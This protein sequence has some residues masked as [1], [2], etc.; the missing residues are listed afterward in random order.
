MA[1]ITLKGNP[2]NTCGDLP[3]VGSAAPEFSL[4]GGGLDDVTL[5]DFQG[6]NVVMSIVPSFDTP[7]CATSVRQ[8][9]E[10]VGADEQSVVLNVSMDLPFAQKRFLR[11]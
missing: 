4:V 10:R 3:A 9:N 8:F 6:K 5:S 11:K 7:V 1:G 2:I